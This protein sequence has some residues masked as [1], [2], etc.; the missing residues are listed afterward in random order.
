M[1]MRIAAVIVAAGDGLRLGA[2]VPKAF[3]PVAGLPMVAWSIDAMRATA[4]VTEVVVAVPPGRVDWCR[5]RL[6]RH[7]A[8]VDLVEGGATRSVSVARALA[9]TDD[10]VTHIVVHDAARP[11]VSAE[12]VRR[13]VDGIG[14]ADGAIA[15]A[16][17]P[18]TIKAAGASGRIARTVSR[19]GLWAAQTPQAFRADRFRDAVARAL[20]EGVLD[21]ATD[22]ASI[23][24]SA[25]RP[26]RLVEVAEA[27]LKVTR[28]SDLEVAAALL[29]ARAG[30]GPVH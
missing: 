30:G 19:D 22:C 13:I 21:G 17:V 25:G 9:A 18:D 16:P 5:A 11:L 12:V 1:R 20:A 2:D 4:G 15:A 10:R 7:A 3:V 8:L 6:G 27:N 26:V 23:M 28:V 14:D 24:E 29:A